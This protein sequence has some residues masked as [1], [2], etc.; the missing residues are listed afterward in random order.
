MK[1]IYCPQCGE[2]LNLRE[3][4]DEGLLPFCNKCEVPYFDWFGQCIIAAV[5]NEYGE[6]ALLK[7]E[8]I[9]KTNW[10]LVAGYIKKGETLEDTAIREVKEETGQIVEKIE[11]ISSYYYEKKELLMV[12]F[13]CEVKK[14]EFNI[15]KEIDEV[16][17][18]S[19]EKAKE[20]LREGSI[21]KQLFET[22]MKMGW[23]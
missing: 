3:I 5:V 20:L 23:G 8:S 22:V 6:I 19:F 12:G 21:A 15:S 7:Q 4:G 10:G 16:E 11:Y 14:R 18:Y 13:R 17:W 2:K 1:F 9:S